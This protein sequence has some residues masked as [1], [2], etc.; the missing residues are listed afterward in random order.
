MSK[1]TKPAK[2][3]AA[4][5]NLTTL[6]AAP[7]TQPT[8]AYDRALFP[9]WLD[10]D[11]N[12]CDAREDALKATGTNVKTGKGCKILS[13]SWID[14]YTG[15][16]ITNPSKLD[17]DHIVPLAAAWREGA[18][19]WNATKRAQYAN[20]PLVLWAVGASPNRQKGDSTADQWKPTLQAVWCAYATRTVQIEVKY[21]L[22]PSD[23]ERAALSDMLA[24][25]PA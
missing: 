6:P 10:P 12:G 7:A 21:Q 15:Q 2:V 1:Y 17:V 3:Q 5:N 23:A 19:T 8:S 13:G 18:S 22:A 20:D 24:T 14:P 9:Q 11:G 4:K 16:T 25:C